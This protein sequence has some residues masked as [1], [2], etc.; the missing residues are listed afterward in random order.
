MDDGAFNLNLV[1]LSLHPL[2]VVHD[3]EQEGIAR[4]KAGMTQTRPWIESTISRFHQS[5]IAEK[6]IQGFQLEP[7][8]VLS[9]LFAFLR[10][11]DHGALPYIA[12]RERG[13]QRR[14]LGAHVPR[15]RRGGHPRADDQPGGGGASLTLALE[16]T[17]RFHQSLIGEKGY[18]S[19][20]NLNLVCLSLHP[21]HYS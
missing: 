16:S 21:V 4:V 3:F 10:Q 14:D 15:S 20:F 17:T 2:R 18:N 5:L 13:T 19:A 9:E 6:D 11:G 8:C 1:C 12:H 7:L